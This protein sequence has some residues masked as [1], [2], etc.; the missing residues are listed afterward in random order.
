MI[1]QW[2][3]MIHHPSSIMHH[4]S[5][6]IR[7]PS[8]IIHDPLWRHLGPPGGVSVV[9]FRAF[10]KLCKRAAGGGKGGPPKGGCFICGDGH[11]ASECVQNRLNQGKP[12]APPSAGKGGLSVLCSV[13]EVQTAVP[14]GGLR[15]CVQPVR[16]LGRKETATQGVPAR[17][18]IPSR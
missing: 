12:T 13:T 10:V 4:G 9:S 6:M 7:G 11:W 5:S 2:L 3:S 8:S 14:E 1:H 15:S 18:I 16:M 17:K